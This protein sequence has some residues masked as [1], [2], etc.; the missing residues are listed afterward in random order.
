MVRVGS[1]LSDDAL[2]KIFV[3]QVT[4]GS[5]GEF[6]ALWKS[7]LPG[8]AL[9]P[10]HSQPREIPYDGDRL[11]LELDQ[12]SEHWESLRDAPGFVIGVSGV[13]AERAAARLLRGAQVGA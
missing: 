13:A 4:V 2:R 3:H 9:K 11:C 1:E 7:R 6:D 5:A 8:I 10:L 12:K